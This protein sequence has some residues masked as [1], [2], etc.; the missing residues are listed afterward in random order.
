[1]S[2]EVPNGSALNPPAECPICGTVVPEF[3]PHGVPKAK[4]D[5]RCPECGSVERHRIIWLFFQRRTDLFTAPTKLLHIAPEPCISRRLKKQDNIHYLSADLNSTAAMMRMD[6]TRI[7]L[8]AESFDVIYASHVLEHIVDD[9]GAMRE[10]HRVLR[11]SGWAVFQV[12]VWGETTREDPTVTD[13][14]ERERRFGQVDHVRM[15]GNDGEFE[16]RLI[17]AGFDVTVDPFAQS[18]EPEMVRRY[19]LMTTENVYFCR[20]TCRNASP[21][22]SVAPIRA[23]K[24]APLSSRLVRGFRSRLQSVGTSS[25]GG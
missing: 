25:K 23:D 12:P 5:R 1:M 17:D 7:D 3:L 15:Y 19:R 22:G 24:K 18:L 14:K 4:P 13:P 21:S 10:L 20:K 6:I 11:P 8:P 9:R 2:P 16:R